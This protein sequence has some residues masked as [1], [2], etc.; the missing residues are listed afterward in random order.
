MVKAEIMSLKVRVGRRFTITIPKEAREKLGIREGDVLDLIVAD[1]TIVLRKPMSL[2][3]FID[4]I[5]P[6]GSIKV[7]LEE[8]SG[9]GRIEDERAME[10]ARQHSH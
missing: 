8:R 5:K 10:L 2:V 3:E 6:K 7:F 9:E 4:S 1:D